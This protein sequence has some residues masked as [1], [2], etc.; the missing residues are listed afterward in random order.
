MQNTLSEDPLGSSPAGL[1]TN[2]MAEV[3]VSL[4]VFGTYTYRVPES[5]QA[6]TSVGHRVLVPFGRKTATGWIVGFP[7]AAPAVEI[8]EILDFPDDAPLFPP[9]MVA[10]FRWLAEYYLYPLGQVIEAALPGGWK[11]RESVSYALPADVS[12]P[13]PREDLQR[14]ILAEV[15][16][17]KLTR[18]ALSRR[19][20]Q[21]VSKE[22]LQGL[23]RDGRLERRR[24]IRA[25]GMRPKTVRHV[26]FV[27]GAGDGEKLSKARKRVLR[28][29][30]AA[31][32]V[33]LPEL[34]RRVPGAARMVRAMETTG[35]VALLDKEVFRDP[36]GEP[37]DIE[38]AP[39]PTEDQQSVIDAVCGVL[40]KG[41]QT[42][43]LTGV[44]GSGKTEVYLRLAKAA[45]GL[46]HAVL[47]LVPEIALISQME[48]RFRSRFGDAVAV[49]HSG[50][51]SGERF[52]Q[53]RRICSGDVSIAV[54]ARSAVFAPFGRLGLIIV[55][56]EHDGSYKQEGGFRY[57]ARDVAVVRAK[58][59][60]A[61]ALLG[62]A[63]PSV[64]SYHNVLSGKFR[65]LKLP[66]R[67]EKRP[68]ASIRIVDLRQHRDARGADRWMTPTLHRAIEERLERKEQVLLFLNRRGF[69]P[70]PICSSC[71]DALR[72]RHCDI[73]LTY[74]KAMGALKC[75]YC[76]FS[77]P[78]GA[79]C[80]SCG[81]TEIRMLGMGTEKVADTLTG[82]F[83]SAQT[84]RMDRD[85]I[86]RKGA[87][88][89]ILKQLRNREID[90][91]VGTQMVAKGHDF[92]GITLVGVLCADQSLHFPD[93]RSGERTFQL[94]AQVAGRAGRGDRPGQV[95]LQTYTPDHFSIR[96]ARQQDFRAF[97]RE[98][99]GFRK[100]LDYPPFSRMALLRITGKRADRTEAF[101][102][103]T[104]NR[105]DELTGGSQS[106]ARSIQRM[107][108]IE[109]PLPRIAN[110]F[111]WQILL[112]GSGPSVLHRFLRTLL[113]A[114]D[115]PSPPAGVSITWDVD[116]YALL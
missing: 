15:E 54:G 87:V 22:V 85:A 114:E 104:G 116:P 24:R 36:F 56:E 94:L 43:L 42:Y 47:V 96:T 7:R 39:H 48:R 41:F 40:G 70:F 101:A 14:R 23:V 58:L 28:V 67:I 111:R 6:A 55:D 51:A 75:H 71:G 98:E 84:V 34:G 38:S 52:D 77:L 93:F 1:E 5:L 64:Q 3:A 25:G 74:H 35:H 65:E 11:A 108:P 110:R 86:A 90:I 20:G 83:P 81:G 27:R 78:A 106:F 80:P 62:S 69:A 49:L 82:M 103:D 31:G 68:L 107:G 57:Q 16:T 95:I 88:V 21:P 30:E 12:G 46:G 92:P 89:R 4:P 32:E 76:G 105:C 66:H 29:V 45:V 19:L 60:G 44:T 17:G 61:V 97:F 53:W 2:A 8:K 18:E 9:Q 109:A 59:D 100:A 10:F 102:R 99:I 113:L 115:S 13:S 26:R 63:T 112:K 91:L 37:V 33:S 73:S 72:C 79:A 50:L